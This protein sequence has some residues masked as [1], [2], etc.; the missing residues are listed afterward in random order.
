MLYEVITRLPS[1]ACLDL[2]PGKPFGSELTY[3]SGKII[4]VLAGKITAALGI[5]AFYQ[6]AF[7][8]HRL[9]YIK[10]AIPNR[11]CP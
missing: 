2:D 10:A 9:E 7:F 4:K 5:Y 6:P 3:I 1:A 11:F 8:Y